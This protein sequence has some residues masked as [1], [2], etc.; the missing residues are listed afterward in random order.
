MKNALLFLIASLAFAE[1]PLEIYW[2]DTEGGA[3]TLIVTP[4]GQSLLADTGNP[5][6]RDPHRI[7][8]VATKH[9]HLK[10]IDYLL[11]THFHSDHV[12]GA[13]ALAKLI[14]IMNYLDHGDSIETNNPA[15]RQRWEAYSAIAGKKR[16]ILSV[17]NKVPLKGIS[18]D[19][20][21]SNGDVLQ[22]GGVANPFCA[23]ATRKSPDPGENGRSLGF[24]LTFGKFS[25][26]DLGDLTWNKELDLACPENHLGQVTMFQATHHG[27]YGD[28]SGAP[29]H[30]WSL[31]PQ[32]IIVNNGPRKG[33][34]ANAWNTIAKT[35]GLEDTWQVHLSLATD[36][37]HNTA[38][39][40]IANPEPTDSCQGHFLK[41]T[42]HADGKF[43]VTNS[44]N[45]FSKNYSTH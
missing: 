11:T 41:A 42:I 36:A 25:F 34:G 39:A 14:P 43:T 33:L 38:E 2:I 20:V 35:P 13:P 1:R 19:I 5:G 32:V 12:G 16:K 21:S 40:Q 17:G 22:T 45:G 31:H 24:K 10:R 15:D 18:V 29:A 30:V 37:A 3:A 26:L 23:D 28:N 9:A 6:D 4:S 27:F 8:D 44:R 7:F